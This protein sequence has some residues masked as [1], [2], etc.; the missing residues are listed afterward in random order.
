QHNYVLNRVTNIGHNLISI[1]KSGFN[2]DTRPSH[3]HS[4]SGKS[5]TL[6]TNSR[7]SL[8]NLIGAMLVGGMIYFELLNKDGKKKTG[9]TLI[10]IC[11]FLVHLQDHC[12]AQSIIIMD[13]TRIHG[14]DNFERIKNL[15]KESTR[16]INIKFL[17]NYLLFL[18]PIGLGFN[19]IRT[20]IKH[21]EIK[22]QS[23][24]STHMQPITGNII[25]DPEN[26]VQVP[27]DNVS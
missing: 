12:P 5:A 10:N 19:M 11:N 26:F 23:E 1:D 8:I 9:T 14:G 18:N 17:P 3:G 4:L 2:S 25:K 6:K 20:Q 16:K 22:S 15:L 13:N 27:S 21:K 24:I 7:A